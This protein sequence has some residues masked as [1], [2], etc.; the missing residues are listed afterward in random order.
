M[1]REREILP[2]TKKIFFLKIAY[3]FTYAKKKLFIINYTLITA[4][5]KKIW[6]S[7]VFLGLKWLSIVIFSD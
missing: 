2:P 7:I 3:Y 6:L 4:D 1:K 5:C